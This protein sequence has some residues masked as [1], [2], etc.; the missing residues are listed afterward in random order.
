MKERQQ[1]RVG[2]RTNM[3]KVHQTILGLGQTPKKEKNVKQIVVKQYIWYC[4]NNFESIYLE[5]H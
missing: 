4:N 3:I 1:C 5:A 2:A